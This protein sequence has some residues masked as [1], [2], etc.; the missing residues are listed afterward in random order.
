VRAAKWSEK[1]AIEHQNNIFSAMKIGQLNR[2]AAEI[3]Q[4][5]IGRFLGDLNF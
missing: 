1:T 2:F 3:F 5:K 4:H